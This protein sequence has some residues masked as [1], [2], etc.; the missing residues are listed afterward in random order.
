MKKLVLILLTLVPILAGAL[1][2]ASTAPLGM[3]LYY[4][5]PILVLVFWFWLGGQYAE[6]DWGMLPSVLIGSAT[7]IASLVLY[8]W[9]FCLESEGTRNL[10]LAGL[11]QMYAGS[12]PLY[13]FSFIFRLL[14]L[15]DMVQTLL[16]HEVLAVI[17]M[18]AVFLA[19][20]RRKKHRNG[21]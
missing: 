12:T 4:A 7:G 8:V 16:V 15:G 2:N 9:Q 19:G 6:T 11:S 17:L 21:A 10:F 14:R 5:L 3:L 1:I 20:Y 18:A 13:V